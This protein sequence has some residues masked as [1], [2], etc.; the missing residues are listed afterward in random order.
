VDIPVAEEV[1]LGE[2]YRLGPLLGAGGMAQVFDGW[3]VRLARSVAVKVLRPDLAAV[4]DLRRR[5]ESEA[6]TAARL[7]HPNVVSVFDAGSDGGR[8]YIVMERLRGETLAD[9]IGRGPLDQAWLLRLA[10]EVLSAL[11]AAH[12][13][14]VIHRD[15]KPS[16]VLLGPDG[17]A[18]VA[19]F[20]I[21][22]VIEDDQERG[23]DVTGTGL[24]LG[25]AA[26]LSPE[27]AMGQP[28][29]PQSD[30]YALGVV[31]YEALTGAKPFVGA[32]AVAIAAAALQ[33][34]A[35]NPLELRPDADPQL[36]AVIGRALAV[37]PAQRYPSAAAMA[38][39]LRRSHPSAGPTPTSIMPAAGARAA[40][41]VPVAGP[42]VAGVPVA[43]ARAT[44]GRATAGR[45]AAGRSAAG[46][47]AAGRSVD[48]VPVA[49]AQAAAGRS[50]RGPSVAWAR[51]ANR[52]EPGRVR[53][54]AT[55]TG[56]AILAAVAVAVVL[57]A[58]AAYSHSGS[59]TGSHT[60]ATTLPP[61]TTSPAPT[62][63]TFPA[64]ATTVVPPIVGVQADPIATALE[65]IANRLA[66][67]TSA[68]AGQLAGGLDEV[69]AITDPASRKAAATSLL[70]QAVQWNSAGQLSTTDY[71]VAA[72]VLHAAGA[73]VPPQPAKQKKGQGG[74]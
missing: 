12:D 8:S 70:H 13:A 41:G 48:G 33:G 17:R 39:D 2:R 46:R 40:G 34:T 23:A 58:V 62:S 27:R 42:S 26:Y 51:G 9:L 56:G 61:P 36:V 44:A 52:G 64:E 55:V 29:T 24:V 3:D 5:F 68:A 54:V 1:V 16:N 6:R 49:G 30:V 45:P 74:G 28:A 4:A 22:R 14:G 50:A 7:A 69:A 73:P 60:A 53:R 32:T 66:T 57:L 25:T 10:A 63:T 59:T 15:I 65:A 18:K 21:A 47:S 20:G 31:M 72:S 43:G 67:S 19:D 71:I 35:R 37:D 11:A 38:A